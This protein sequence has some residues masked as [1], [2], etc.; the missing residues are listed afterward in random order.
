M[1]TPCSATAMERLTDA[2]TKDL[3]DKPQREMSCE[4]AAEWFMEN[5]DVKAVLTKL[6]KF[7]YERIP[8]GDVFSMGVAIKQVQQMGRDIWEEANEAGIS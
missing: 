3:I 6:V 2:G 5:G 8:T 1:K 7:G 4:E